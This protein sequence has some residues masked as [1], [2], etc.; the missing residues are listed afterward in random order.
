[1]VAFAC[2]NTCSIHPPWRQLSV[3]V[4]IKTKTFWTDSRD[5][6]VIVMRELYHLQHGSLGKE[7]KRTPCEFEPVDM[8]AH[9]LENVLEVSLSVRRVIRTTYL[10]QTT[11]A[12]LLSAGVRADEAESCF[13]VLDE[14]LW[15]RGFRTKGRHQ[16]CPSQWADTNTGPQ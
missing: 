11:L 7:C 10:G 1:M 4:N 2:V 13:F 14:S 6:D 8:V 5:I 3:P 12:G 9:R 15:L 16:P